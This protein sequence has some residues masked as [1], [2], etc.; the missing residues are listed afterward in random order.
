MRQSCVGVVCLLLSFVPTPLVSQNPKPASVPYTW[1]NV[2]IVGGGFVPG[3]IF[4][5]T[6]KNLRYARTDIGGAYRWSE[7]ARRWEPLLDWVSLKDMNLMGVES[8]AVDPADPNRVYLACG[9]Y[10]NPLTPNGAILR[11][12]DRGQT[13]QRAEVPFKFGGNESG[14]GNGERLVVD[15]N[16]G[17]VLYLGTRQAGLWRSID[18]GATWN[19]VESLPDITEPPDG[20]GDDW[21]SQQSRGVGVVFEIFDKASGSKGKPTPTIYAGASLLGRNNLF[22]SRDAGKTWQPVP[23]QPTQYRP[24][25]AVLASDGNLYI[26]Y[27]TIPGPWRMDNGAVWK[28]N[29]KTG[30]WTDVTPE[31]PEPGEKGFGYVGISVDARNPQMLIASTFD[32]WHSGRGN[33]DIFRTTDGGKSWKPV[34]GGGG[35]LDPALSPYVAD[36]PLHWFFDIEIDPANSDHAM[37]TTGYGGW[38]TF[39]LTAMDSGAPTK[40]SVMS[41]GI[42]ETVALD[43]LSPPKGARVIT[44][45]GD[46][47]GFVHWD[48]DKPAPEHSSQPPLFGNTTGLA[49][50]ENDPDILVRVGRSSMHHPGSNI[51]YSLD[52][53]RSWQPASMPQPNSAL[54]HIAVSADGKTWVWSPEHSPVYFTHDR[55]ATWQESKGL[56]RDTRVIADRVNPQKFYALALFDGKLLVSADGGENFT[57]QPLVLPKGLP[58]SRMNRGDDRGGQDRVY[59]TPGAEGDLWIAAF[60]G[61]YHSLDSGKTFNNPGKVEEIHAFGFGKAAPGAGYPALYLIGTVQGVRGIFR[62]DDIAKTWVRINDDQHQWGLLLHITGDPKQY[63]RVYVGSHGRGILYGDPVSRH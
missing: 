19:R 58:K 36:T 62:S 5:P 45:I 33:D 17:R 6:E 31:K 34:F 37:F 2:Q 43:L 21:V 24:H 55:G 56:L 51:G 50:A 20:K 18:S 25:R 53:G 27:G 63:G 16:D 42:E 61:L 41:T 39:N 28:L 52:S 35:A 47:G 60:D 38:E 48:L 7:P 15:P 13:F 59:A 1:K 10:T 12:T 44:A 14:R 32:R 9:T 57:E 40:W 4:H 26:A 23:G 3:I 22:R 8:I 54:G 11:S 49:C 30:E 29:T 46:Y